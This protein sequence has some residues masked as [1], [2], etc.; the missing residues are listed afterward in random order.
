MQSKFDKFDELAPELKC[1][2]AKNLS[3]RDLVNLAQTSRYHLALF[4]PMIDVRKLFALLHHVTR[5]E[6][7][8]VKAMLTQDISMCLKWPWP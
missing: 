1:E 3:N 6:H 5:G 7:D 8:A 4:K 2:I